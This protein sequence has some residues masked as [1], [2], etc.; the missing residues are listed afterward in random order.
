[1][2]LHV[3][4]VCS[5]FIAECYSLLIHSPMDG[6]SVC[7]HFGVA[8]NKAPVNICV[9]YT[10]T[11]PYTS[12][13]VD[14]CFNYSCKYLGV[15]WLDHMVGIR[16]TF[17][18]TVKLFSE[19]GRPFHIPTSNVQEFLLLLTCQYLGWSAFSS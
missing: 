8:T 18:G 2:L 13:C 16:L 10:N 9:F 3:S 1:M 11:C 4:R 17:K 19:G 14:I 15:E 6:Y 7:F 5:F 12:S